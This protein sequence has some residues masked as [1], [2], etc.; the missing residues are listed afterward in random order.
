MP[1]WRARAFLRGETRAGAVL[2]SAELLLRRLGFDVLLAMA[3][4]GIYSV[5]LVFSAGA[6]LFFI[7][8]TLLASDFGQDD[9]VF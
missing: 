3:R 9:G 4:L 5:T 7:P 8:R 2:D 6:P 1:P